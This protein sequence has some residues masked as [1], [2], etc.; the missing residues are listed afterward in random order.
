MLGDLVTRMMRTG[1]AQ[2]L[3]KGECTKIK[4][5]E[6]VEED[7]LLCIFAWARKN[8]HGMKQY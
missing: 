4:Q 8:Y 5:K 3:E 2:P 6:K 1:A 7:E